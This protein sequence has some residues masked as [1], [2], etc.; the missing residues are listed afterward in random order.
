MDLVSEVES[1]SVCV[2]VI[3][4]GA[5]QL[6]EAKRKG[7]IKNSLKKKEICME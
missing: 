6:R 3:L 2:Y 7:V 5:V 4:C 1:L